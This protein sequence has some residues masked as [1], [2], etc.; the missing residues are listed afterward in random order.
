M[1]VGACPTPFAAAYVFNDSGSGS[2]DAAASMTYEYLWIAQNGAAASNLAAYLAAHSGYGANIRGNISLV[3]QAQYGL[4][5]GSIVSGG[6]SA[7]FGCSSYYLRYELIS[8]RAFE[9]FVLKG[10]FIF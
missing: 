9:N 8:I 5:E 3:Q 1:L 6:A 7:S 4:A 10:S 2:G